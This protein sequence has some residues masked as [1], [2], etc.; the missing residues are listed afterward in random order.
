MDAHLPEAN[1]DL[2]RLVHDSRSVMC[3]EASKTCVGETVEARPV[4]V[5]PGGGHWACQVPDHVDDLQPRG[6]RGR[7][8]H[9]AASEK[10]VECVSERV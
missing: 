3:Q 8:R 5:P 6:S 7:V 9:R 1:I 4:G 10:F 2:C